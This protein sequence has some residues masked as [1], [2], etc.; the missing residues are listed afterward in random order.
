MVILQLWLLP[1]IPFRHFAILPLSCMNFWKIQAVIKCFERS[2]VQR[3]EDDSNDVPLFMKTI[4]QMTIHFYLHPFVE[5][6]K[7][8]PCGIVTL[9]WT[10]FLNF[11]RCEKVS[12]REKNSETGCESRE[13][14]LEEYENENYHLL[15]RS[16]MRHFPQMK[17]TLSHEP[18]TL[19]MFS[20]VLHL[21][22]YSLTIAFCTISQQYHQ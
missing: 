1:L 2:T 3:I 18:I 7:H 19:W 12:K 13:R 8:I 10:C 6:T 9:R 22:L 14:K 15:W 21:F 11:L 16:E 5:R 20:T 17:T 4:M